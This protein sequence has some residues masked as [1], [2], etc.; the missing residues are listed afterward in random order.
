MSITFH[1]ANNYA[2]CAANNLNTIREEECLCVYDGHANSNCP[3]CKGT[4]VDRMEETPFEMNVANGNGWALLEILGI[5]PDYSGCED[6]QKFLDGVAFVRALNNVGHEPLVTEAS[7]ET[8]TGGCRIIH[9][10]RTPEQVQRYLDT[11]EVIA[12]EA[13]RRGVKITWG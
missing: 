7:E 8:G 4:G 1:P 13:K 9:C 5:T 2:F 11:I 10:G 6:A 12:T 3:Y